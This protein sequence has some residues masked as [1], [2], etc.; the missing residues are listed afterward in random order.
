MVPAEPV[1]D[2]RTQEILTWIDS[3]VPDPFPLRILAPIVSRIRFFVT[4]R[5]RNVGVG[6]VEPG[7]YLVCPA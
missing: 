2:H 5:Q 1:P 4:L 3:A 6:D 7:S